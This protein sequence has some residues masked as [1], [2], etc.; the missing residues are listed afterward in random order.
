MSNHLA[1][2]IRL[3]TAIQTKGCSVCRRWGPSALVTDTGQPDRPTVCPNC[4]RSV[5]IEALIRL[6]GVRYSDI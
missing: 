2:L 1:R 5:P 3:E 4:R 6:E